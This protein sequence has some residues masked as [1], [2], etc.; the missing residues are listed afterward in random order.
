MAKKQAAKGTALVQWDKEFAELAGKAVKGMEVATGKFIS[1]RAGQM[2]LGGA[3]VQNNTL[4]A[5]VVA[6]VHSN[7]Y[8]DPDVPFNP[9][10]PQSPLCYAFGADKDEM[11]PHSQ[12]P[13]KQNANC[14]NCPMNKFESAKRGK[15]KACKNQIRLALISEDDL[16]NADSL[17]SLDIV[18]MNVPVMSAK[19]WA[20]YATNKLAN[21][22]KRPYWSVVTTI[23][24]VPDDD[25][26]FKVLFELG[27]VIE[28]GNLFPVLKAAWE[29]NM[30]T[31][32]FPYAP[33]RAAEEAPTARKKP[34][35]FAARR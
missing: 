14:A 9:K 26:Q 35:K 12:A 15:G 28:N 10:Q 6:A 20:A 25:S 30:E 23:K 33:P 1:L 34:S 31:I 8:Y 22:I 17:D 19:N 29:K 2:T 24:V 32:G 13:E 18:Y 4:R 27:D 3:N 16:E 7:A 5:V 21:G 11:E